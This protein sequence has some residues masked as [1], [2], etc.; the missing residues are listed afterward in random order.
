[1]ALGWHQS[2]WV[3]RLLAINLVLN[4]RYALL[5]A[6]LVQPQAIRQV[7]TYLDI[8]DKH[9]PIVCFI[10]SV[11]ESVRSPGKLAWVSFLSIHSHSNFA[12]ITA[13]FSCP[14]PSM[15]ENSLLF[16][17]NISMLPTGDYQ[18][19]VKPLSCR[20]HKKTSLSA[21]QH[22]HTHV[23]AFSSA[24]KLVLKTQSVLRTQC[25]KVIRFYKTS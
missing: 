23:C 19:N 18:L 2:L 15:H 24:E 14:S 1:M 20:L 17:R 3:T 22:Y 25:E 11:E 10:V 5:I 4:V 8:G 13:V 21:F 16:P 9:L 7:W 12:A 6:D